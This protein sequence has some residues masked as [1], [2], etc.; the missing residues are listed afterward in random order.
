MMPHTSAPHHTPWLVRK[1]HQFR[2]LSFAAVLLAAVLHLWGKPVS[3]G[4]WAYL[5]A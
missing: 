2:G 1:H 5:V 4:L 3:L